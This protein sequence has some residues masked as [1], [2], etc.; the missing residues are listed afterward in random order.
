M[1]WHD[2]RWM[3]RRMQYT[4]R[5][6]DRHGILLYAHP[7]NARRGNNCYRTLE[8]LQIMSLVLTACMNY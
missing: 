6:S 3:P 4:D 1:V 5:P 8:K 2:F 7:C